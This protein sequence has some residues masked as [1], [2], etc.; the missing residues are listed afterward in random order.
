[1]ITRSRPGDQ[2]RVSVHAC[3]RTQCLRPCLLPV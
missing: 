2:T 3:G 1:L